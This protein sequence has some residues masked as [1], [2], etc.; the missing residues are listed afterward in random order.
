MIRSSLPLLLLIAACA[1]RDAATL[2][3][4][5]GRRVADLAVSDST[6]LLLYDPS[7]CFSCGT[8]LPDW[9]A[10]RLR[11]PDRVRLVLTGTPTPG[12]AALLRAGRVTVD[13]IAPGGR[14]L[15]RGKGYRVSL[16]VAG[17]EQWSGTAAPDALFPAFPIPS[18]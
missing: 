1:G 16:L 17:R 10:Y 11:H 2:E 5:D 12:E 3:L 13:G 18:R 14:E 9:V 4:A 8:T 15:T 7:A 6:A